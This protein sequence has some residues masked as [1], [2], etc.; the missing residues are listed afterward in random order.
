MFFCFV[1]F[2]CISPPTVVV[3]WYQ[4][5]FTAL[6]YTMVLKYMYYGT[7]NNYMVVLC[8][9]LK[10]YGIFYT[11]FCKCYRSNKTLLFESE[12]TAV[13]WKCTKVIPYYLLK[14]TDVL[15]K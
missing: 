15:F 7:T 14:Y 1:F 13:L 2:T 9:Y 3:L 10:C 6:K 11:F 8:Y 12:Q 5:G 4:D